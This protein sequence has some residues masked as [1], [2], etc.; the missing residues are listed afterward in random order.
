MVTKNAV[1]LKI[2]K[3]IFSL[4]HT[5]STQFQ[6]QS[7]KHLKAAEIIQTVLMKKQRNIEKDHWYYIGGKK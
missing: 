7:Q 3:Q 2:S 1:I 5:T 6:V 4:G